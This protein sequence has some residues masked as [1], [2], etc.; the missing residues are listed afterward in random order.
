[1]QKKS[2][3]YVPFL[4]GFF[5]VIVILIGAI[6]IPEKFT[7][8]MIFLQK[9]LVTQF[10]WCFIF[11]AFFIM[12][13]TLAIICSPIGDIRIGGKDAKPDFT[14][15]RWFAIS[16]CSGI[17]IGILFWGIGEPIYH[18]ISPP[19]NL[20]IEPRSH[21]AALFA[22]SQST[23][24]WSIAQY[25]MYAIC[26]VIFAIMAFNEKKSL[27]IMNG[28][29]PIIEE[30]YYTLVKNIIHPACLFS[31][32]CTVV[33]ST[34]ALI[35]MVASCVSWLLGV[36]RT[37]ALHTI[38]TVISTSLF[39]GSSVTGLKKG[40]NFLS[41]LNTRMFFIILFYVLLCGPTLFTLNIGTETFGYMLQ[42]FIH[43]STLVSTEFL[44][45]RWSDSWLIVY[46]GAFF[47]Y[48]PPIG[49]F[50]ARLGKG[51]TI[52]QFLLMNVL[53]P[54]AFVFLWINTFGSL[55][56][57]YQWTGVVDVWN[58]VQTQGLE[59]TVI[60]I[61]QGFPLSG[62]LITIFIFVT[63][64]SFVTL[65]DPM[66]SVLA[67]ISTRGI[68]PEEAPGILK[69]LWGATIGSVALAVITL[70]GV[71]ALRQ[72]FLFGGFLMMFLLLVFCWCI[73]REGMSL[74][75]RES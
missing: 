29:A 33:S 6:I 22:I 10:G 28:L 7:E 45:D 19:Q 62:V 8:F 72:M 11:T 24:H 39:V 30:K 21:T 48:A 69:I 58:F 32:C 50:L 25:C 15:F 18:F 2:V 51:R 71:E 12:V 59:S 13:F 35:M 23:V 42:N 31:I 74:L 47:A 20:G 55:A 57:Y 73:V 67:T 64:I 60:A 54:S 70:C 9:N 26:G 5:S 66:T 4:L 63:I 34:G 61:L 36:P 52:R 65:V 41:W 56:I 43:N 16:L 1:M 46:M 17:G 38:V 37:F 68:S 75:K 27:S 44:P 49:I 3:D 40:M 53:A 14:L